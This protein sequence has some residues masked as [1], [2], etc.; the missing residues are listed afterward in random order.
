MAERHDQQMK[1]DRAKYM[2]SHAVQK[3]IG[4]KRERHAERSK[5]DSKPTAGQKKRRRTL[6]VKVSSKKK[7]GALE[8]RL[9]MKMR[10][11]LS[12]RPRKR[13]KREGH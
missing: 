7:T 12:L 4:V 8:Q 13:K 9:A 1:H 5:L 2:C 11:V 3:D 6:R 10:Q